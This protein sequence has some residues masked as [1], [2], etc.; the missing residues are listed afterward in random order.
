M[1]NRAAF[2]LGAS[3]SAW[4]SPT[5]G[6][7]CIMLLPGNNS[8][9]ALRD[10]FRQHLSD[11]YDQGEIE[12]IFRIAIEEKLGVIW[13]HRLLDVRFSESDINRVSPVLEALATGK[14]L[15][16]ILGHAEF[17]GCKLKVDARVLIPRPET[18]ELC[19][20]ILNEN[21]KTDALRVLDIGTGSGC[22]P[23]SLKKHATAWT[24]WAIE[25][26]AGAIALAAENATEN[27]VQ[28]HLLQ[29]NILFE[30]ALIGSYDIIVSNPPYIA[31]EEKKDI[32][33]NVLIHE[34]HLALFVPDTDTLLF[35]RSIS[36][37]AFCALNAGGKLYFEI[38]ERFGKETLAVMK[39]A[40]F[41]KCLVIKDLSDK[42]RFASGIKP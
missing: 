27:K 15:Q 29:Q 10:L 23:I 38:N 14:P 25:V 21:S 33:N 31:E 18:E 40:G 13:S 7:F 9:K 34:P 39:A 20:I 41:A 42:N 32:L 19:T 4:V 30:K 36:Q 17:L 28:V 26:D 3:E 37:L 12:A 6:Y 35:Y 24:V 16:Y 8:F 1:S 22:I 11:L 2:F 5:L